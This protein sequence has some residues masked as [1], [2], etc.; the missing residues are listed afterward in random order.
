MGDTTS[1]EQSPLL[2]KAT[3]LYMDLCETASYIQTKL[4]NRQ[5]ADALG[6]L[7]HF[8]LM[9]SELYYLTQTMT[10]FSNKFDKDV[11]KTFAKWEKRVYSKENPIRYCRYTL[12]VFRITCLEICNMGIVG[13]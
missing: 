9:F 13:M 6:K 7:E 11:Q 4:N 5:Y 12:D 1:I 8:R 3:F 10:D 2:Y